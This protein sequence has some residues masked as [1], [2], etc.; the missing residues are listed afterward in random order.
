MKTSMDRI[1]ALKVVSG[2]AFVSLV[3]SFWQA[4]ERVHMLKNP[5]LDLSCNLNPVVDCSGVLDHKLAALFGFPNAL[6]GVAMFSIVFALAVA[7]IFTKSPN[8]RLQSALLLVSAIGAAFSVWFFGVS[9]YIIGKACIFCMFIWPSSIISFWFLLLDW[10]ESNASGGW[11][12]DLLKFGKKHRFD[13]L[14]GVFVAMV[15][16]FL[17]RF[18][19]YYF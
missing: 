17:Y 9:L 18:R 4:A 13:V 16:L 2:A 1:T 5:T 7:A 14:V 15:I 12:K 3:A 6:L 8:K 10:L 19:E 11:Q